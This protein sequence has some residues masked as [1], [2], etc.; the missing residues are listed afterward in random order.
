MNNWISVDVNPSE[1]N[2]AFKGFVPVLVSL[3]NGHVTEAKF[4]PITQS[5][6][7]DFDYFLIGTVTHWMPLP[8]APKA[9]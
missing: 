2:E 4:N 5:F 9:D 7:K 6:M 8:S 1:A 3:A